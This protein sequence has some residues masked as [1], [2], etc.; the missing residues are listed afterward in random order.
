MLHGSTRLTINNLAVITVVYQNYN[1]LRD[2]IESL[3]KQLNKNFQL[4]IVDLSDKKQKID[5]S[6]VHRPSS[7]VNGSNLGYAHGVNIGLQEAI[8]QGFSKFC[9]INN[10]TFFEKDFVSSVL[11]STINHPS[12]IIGGKIYYAPGYEYHKSRY[13][14]SDL[15]KV[16]WYAGGSVNWNH[17]LTPHYGVDEVETGKYNKLEK[18][19]FVNGCLMCFD[20]SVIEKVGFWDESYFLYFED[21][22]FCERAKQKKIELWY[23]PTII[24]WHK[25]AQ[26]TGGSGSQIHLKYQKKNQLV[27][28]IKYAPLRTKFHLLKN[29]ILN[30]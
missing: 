16:L 3:Q 24:I 7:I 23:D 21:S 29:Y 25:N 18:T 5:L 22:D 30:T 19:G 9:V 12:S 28:G 14:K 10:D 13:K 15:G 20:K 1:T 27:F 11:Q 26:S 8:K 6:T 2:F 4:F 17:A